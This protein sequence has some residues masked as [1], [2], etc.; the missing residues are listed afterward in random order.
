MSYEI[1]ANLFYD[2]L[3]NINFNIKEKV[4]NFNINYFNNFIFKLKEHNLDYLA[5]VRGINDE[6]NANFKQETVSFIV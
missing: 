4:I 5:I 6:T 2:K 3:K 1:T